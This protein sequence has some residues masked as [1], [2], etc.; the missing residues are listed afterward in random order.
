MVG[1][2]GASVCPVPL[3]SFSPAFSSPPILS[4]HV[5]YMGQSALLSKLCDPD[6]PIKMCIH[7]PQGL[8]Q[9]ED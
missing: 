8:V 9:R 3:P 4:V 1:I 6:L 2:A 5:S 7:G